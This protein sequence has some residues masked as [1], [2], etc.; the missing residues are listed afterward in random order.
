MLMVEIFMAFGVGFL[1]SYKAKIEL[2]KRLELNRA[3]DEE[4]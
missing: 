2:D 4:Q 1:I 3:S